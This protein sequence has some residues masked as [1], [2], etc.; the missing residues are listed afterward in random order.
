MKVLQRKTFE[1]IEDYTAQYMMELIDHHKIYVGLWKKE[2]YEDI[3]SITTQVGCRTQCALFCNVKKFI[4]DIT[5]KEFKYQIESVIEKEK[6]NYKHIKVSMV[7][8]GEPFDNVYINDFIKIVN[9]MGIPYLKIST[10][11]PIECKDT[12]RQAFFMAKDLDIEIQLQISL[13]STN[14]IY[15]NNYVARPLMTLQEI[16]DL[17]KEIY[18]QTINKNK[19]YNYIT[20]SL[21]IYEESEFN[22]SEIQRIFDKKI[23]CIRLRDATKSEER[24]KNFS[25]ITENTFQLYKKQIEE[26][27]FIFIDGRS[28]KIAVENNLTIGLY[29]LEEVLM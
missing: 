22:I 16:S 4:R 12:I 8:E 25:R 10:S 17:G 19:K 14:D 24:G 29:K 20:L 18:D 2:S 21:T 15:R 27:G 1:D 23:F 26:A 6:L 28:A 5:V 7:K 13:S 3:I 11:V 9:S